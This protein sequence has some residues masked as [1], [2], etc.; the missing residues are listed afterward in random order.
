MGVSHLLTP[1]FV[2]LI[3]TANGVTKVFTPEGLLVRR[4]IAVHLL[5]AA[6]CLSMGVAPAPIASAAD[7]P[8]GICVWQD[9]DPEHDV[10]VVIDWP[11]R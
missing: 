1:A 7:L 9:Q 10:C 2:D 4:V 11:E 3:P 5:L 8:P 6:A